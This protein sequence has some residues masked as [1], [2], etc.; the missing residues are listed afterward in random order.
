MKKLATA[1]TLVQRERSLIDSLNPFRFCF[2]RRVEDAFAAFE[3]HVCGRM[4]GCKPAGDN[5]DE[6]RLAGAIVEAEERRHFATMHFQIGA[7]RSAW[8]DR[9][10]G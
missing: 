10:C 6:R 4:S 5:L 7:P 3:D 8:I 1:S 2:R 9:N